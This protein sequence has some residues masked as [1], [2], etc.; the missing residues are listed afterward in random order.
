MAG[1]G[2][3][4]IIAAIAGAL[5]GGGQAYQQV[6]E[7]QRQQE[8]QEQAARDREWQRQ[9]ADQAQ[10]DRQAATQRQQ[11]SDMLAAL[12]PNAALTPDQKAS[13]DK[14]GLGYRY[15]PVPDVD[16]NHSMF[17]NIPLPGVP[18]VPMPT[19]TT[20]TRVK[21]TYEEQTARDT[22]AQQKQDAFNNQMKLSDLIRTLPSTAQTAVRVGQLTGKMPTLNPDE[23]VTPE[24]KLA[25]EVTKAQTLGPI[26][27]QQA[28]DRTKGTEAARLPFQ[29]KLHE[30]E[31]QIDQK[32][33]QTADTDAIAQAIIRGEQPP[34]LKGLY[35]NGA[36][37]RAS[38][39]KNGYNLTQATEDW[40]ATS[41]YLASANSLPPQRLRQ[42]VDFVD[43]SLGTVEDLAQQWKSKGYGPLSRA[44]LTAAANGVAGPD[45][46]SLATRFQAQIADVTSEL[47]TVY[48]GG[49][50]STDESLKLAAKNLSADWSEKALL[51]N[52]AQI[53][54][55]LQYRRNS[56]K[57]APIAGTSANN[58]Y[59]P[60]AAG[61]GAASAGAEAPGAAAPGTAPPASSSSKKGPAIGTER[62]ING[63]RAKWDGQG[64]VA[65]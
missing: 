18:I 50:S 61:R 33:A 41:K 7:Q 10:R 55:N 42:A 23:F 4:N 2:W 25:N 64:W 40:N 46:Q 17:E 36:A 53:R 32:Y 35:R 21:P 19:G 26:E 9:Q 13:V 5:S 1:A 56:L 47:G 31:K 24:Q 48:K 27:T 60:G 6:Q 63:Q 28:I 38:L 58:P 39:A 57:S 45:A 3:D 44:A 14:A 37:V 51:D 22:A 54:Q 65:Q 34:D 30:G 59:A 62:M 49:N 8:E 43:G 52:V 16:M 11:V 20:T 15:Q 12:G 29:L